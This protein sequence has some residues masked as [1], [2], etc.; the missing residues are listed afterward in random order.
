MNEARRGKRERDM[1]EEEDT[2]HM[3]EKKTGEASEKEKERVCV[4]EVLS[5]KREREVL[6]TSERKTGKRRRMNVT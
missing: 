1:H 3:S 4:R 2:C 6:L 5:I